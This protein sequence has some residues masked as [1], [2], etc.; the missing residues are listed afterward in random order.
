MRNLPRARGF[1]NQN[2]TGVKEEPACPAASAGSSSSS[3]WR[4]TGRGTR[5]WVWRQHPMRAPLLAV[6]K[7]G[8][9]GGDG[10]SIGRFKWHQWGAAA[11]T[12]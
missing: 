8:G 11:G 6:C 3:R 10:G 12:K 1:R 4:L 5:I 7:C 2:Q 9:R